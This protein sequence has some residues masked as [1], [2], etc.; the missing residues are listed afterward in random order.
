MIAVW[1]YCPGCCYTVRMP[2][3]WLCCNASPPKP[4]PDQALV[5]AAHA[6]GGIK[7]VVAIALNL[8]GKPWTKQHDDI[9]W[10]LDGQSDLNV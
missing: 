4:F 5:E 6:V 9:V 3:T 1:Q 8:T 7:A 2:R 10:W